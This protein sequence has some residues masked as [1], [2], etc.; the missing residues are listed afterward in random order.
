MAIDTTIQWTD[1]TVNPTKGCDGCELWNRNRKFCYAGKLT[2]RFGQSN[3][4]LADDFDVVEL[5][6]RR[7]VEA[8]R[9]SDCVGKSRSN[10]PWLSGLPRLIFV[11]D[12]ADNFSKSVTFDYLHDEVIVSINSTEGQR[13]QWQWLTKRPHRMAAFSKWLEK[14]SIPWP[15]NLWA[16]TSVTTQS[17]TT[18][19]GA[20]M[21]VG[22]KNTL[23]FVSVE[24]QWES[25]DLLR[26]L[27]RLDWVIQ[28][29]Q[30]GSH[31]HPFALDWADDLREQCREFRV[32]YFLKQLGSCVTVKGAKIRDHRGHGGEWDKWPARLRV[33]QMPISVGRRRSRSVRQRKIVT[34][35]QS[36]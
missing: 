7:V 10:K 9:W 24:P 27:P 33:R 4:G 2:S 25:I 15:A 34:S 14:R 1:S 30:S 20:L 11:G 35:P 5:A 22:D 12:M 29:G 26:W 23:R 36:R 16:G 17:R 3:T 8:S 13:H 21:K 19:L 32:P 31:D 28:G 6:S 18:R